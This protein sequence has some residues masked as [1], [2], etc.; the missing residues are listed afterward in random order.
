MPHKI[1]DKEIVLRHYFLPI[2][3]LW[4]GWCWFVKVQKNMWDRPFSRGCDISFLPLIFSNIRHR[5]SSSTKETVMPFQHIGGEYFPMIHLFKEA[6]KIL[7]DT[8]KVCQIEGAI[9]THTL[10]KTFRYHF[11]QWMWAML[12]HIFGH[13]SLSVTF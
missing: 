5:L 6:W 11:N 3:Q 2:I 9:G 7:N 12:L 4:G 13:F 1:S 8:A 10:R